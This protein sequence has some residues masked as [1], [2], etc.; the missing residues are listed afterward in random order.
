MMS[1]K[2]KDIQER[3]Y[4]FSLGVVRTT[5]KFPRNSEGFAIASQL[6]RS[7]TSIP[8]NLFE[9]SAGVSRKDFVQFLSY[10]KKSAVETSFWL[11]FSKDLGILEEKEYRAFS[12]ECDQLTRIVSRIILNSKI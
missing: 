7:S 10:A 5:R 11:M 3:A 2:G 9:G 8:A 6:I 12:D 1:N 4:R